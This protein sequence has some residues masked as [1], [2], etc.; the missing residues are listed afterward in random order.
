ME[1]HV[2]IDR[3]GKKQ[4][5]KYAM[6]FCSMCMGQNSSF[7]IEMKEKDID[8]ENNKMKLKENERI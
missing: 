7:E 2:C 6:M 4:I 3:E 5:R 8:E 1:A